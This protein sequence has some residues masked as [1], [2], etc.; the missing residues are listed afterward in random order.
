MAAS[1]MYI[2]VNLVK[3]LEALLALLKD[4]SVTGPNKKEILDITADSR[5]V[6]SGTLFIALDGATVDG[7]DFVQKA[8]RPS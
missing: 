4:A 7:H 5:K 6:A 2:G 8:V 3:N 1:L